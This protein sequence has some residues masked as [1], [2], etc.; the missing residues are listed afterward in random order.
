MN[1]DEK[2]IAAIYGAIDSVNEQLPS[3]RKLK[4]DPSTPLAGVGGL[5]SIELV[6]LI[7]ATE[8]K[9]AEATG[10]NISL[11]DT[12]SGNDANVLQSVGTLAQHIS[13]QLKG[14]SAS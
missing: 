13:A 2:V 4:K 9:V 10:R 6:N 11:A 5:D 12:A 1:N 3:E 7:V 8:D 14:A